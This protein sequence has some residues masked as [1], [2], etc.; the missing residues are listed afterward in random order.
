MLATKYSADVANNF[1]TAIKE[2]PNVYFTQVYFKWDIIKDADD[3]KFLDCY[4]ASGA[5]YLVSNDS[6]FLIL[7]AVLFP[8]VI[9]LRIDE[10]KTILEH[11][12]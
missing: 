6:D 3:N 4:V 5:Q 1:L 8:K 7:K 11:I 2:L 12:H 9:V 10:F